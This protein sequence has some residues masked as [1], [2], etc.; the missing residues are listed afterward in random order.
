V[1]EPHPFSAQLPMMSKE[2]L[3]S[4]TADIRENGQ[5]EPIL[6][7]EGKILDGRNRYKACLKA[8]VEPLTEKFIGTREE[9]KSLSI[10][11]NLVRR[12]L[13]ASQK[14]MVLVNSGLISDFGGDRQ[15]RRGELSVRSTAERFGV[16]HV[17]VYKAL[18]V[19]QKDKSGELVQKVLNGELSVSAAENL[20]AK[21]SDEKD[22]KRANWSARYAPFA[23][24]L[25]LLERLV[26]SSGDRELAAILPFIREALSEMEKLNKKSKMKPQEDV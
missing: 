18:N 22:T 23:K 14:A 9:A 25:E 2:E 24:K 6:L 26:A 7:F 21:Q 4:L 16:N 1:L 12:H 13:T 8:G 15:Y 11:N 17:S 19:K 10:S 5:K 20:L 3:E